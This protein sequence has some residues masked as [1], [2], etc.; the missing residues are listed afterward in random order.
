MGESQEVNNFR[1]QHPNWISEAQREVRS[2]AVV[3]KNKKEKGRRLREQEKRPVDQFQFLGMDPQEKKTVVLSN[4]EHID[5]IYKM[6]AYNRAHP[7]AHKNYKDFLTEWEKS[8][9][10]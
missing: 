2:R 6:L 7:Q 10:K 4:E 3:A 1:L 5:L 8:S 9:D